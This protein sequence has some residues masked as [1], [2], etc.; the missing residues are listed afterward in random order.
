MHGK[1]HMHH[2]RHEW[3]RG[4]HGRGMFPIVPLLLFFGFV[5]FILPKLGFLLPLLL[6]GGAIWWMSS[7]STRG[8]WGGWSRDQW[9]QWS[10]EWNCSDEDGEKAK[11]VEVVSEKPKRGDD[12]VEYV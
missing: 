6:I 11:R 4:W 10:R 2:M 3:G 7:S 9:Q 1:H 8:R 12:G 5:F